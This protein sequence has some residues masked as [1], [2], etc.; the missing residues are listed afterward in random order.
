M[1]SLAEAISAALTDPDIAAASQRTAARL[2][3][4]SPSRESARLI[5][6]AFG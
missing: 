3:G 1:D 6:E 2:A 4:M 5:E